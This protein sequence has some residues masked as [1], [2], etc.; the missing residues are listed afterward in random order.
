MPRAQSGAYRI[1]RYFQTASLTEAIG[2]LEIARAIV[3]GRREGKAGEVIAMPK[4]PRRGPGRPRK[5]KEIA[6]PP[7]GA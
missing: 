4:P 6:D 7:P 2:M 1:A 3:D 5:V